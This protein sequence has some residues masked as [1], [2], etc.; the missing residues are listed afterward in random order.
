[1]PDAAIDAVSIDEILPVAEI[2]PRLAEL[3]GESLGERP[4]AAGREGAR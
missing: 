2:G 3:A 4:T 1:M